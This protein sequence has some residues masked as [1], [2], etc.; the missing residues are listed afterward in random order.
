MSR[1][2]EVSKIAVSLE[3]IDFNEL[4]SNLEEINTTDIINTASAAAVST[5]IN[6]APEALNT[7]AELSAALNDDQNF[8]TTVTNELSNK[9]SMSS[10]STTY[11]TKSS[12]TFS[13]ISTFEDAVVSQ[14]LNVSKI[15]EFVSTA[16]ITSGSATLNYNLSNIF[17]I[18]SPSSNFNINLTNVPTTNDQTFTITVLVLQ[19]STGYIPN[20]LSIDGSSQTIKWASNVIPVAT[21]SVGKIDIF[22]FSLIR[23]SSSWTI[24]GTSSTNF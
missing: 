19:G 10:A 1:A 4:V 6:G 2:R 24:L 7:L 5:L 23:Q 16:T 15:N 22:N 12:P 8:A 18:S 17:Y 9:L 20:T 11:A 21:N 13:G 3:G 14:K